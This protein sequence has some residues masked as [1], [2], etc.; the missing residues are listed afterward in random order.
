MIYTLFF[1][2]FARILLILVS[3]KRMDLIFITDRRL[4]FSFAP[5]VT[6]KIIYLILGKERK[7]WASNNKRKSY[8]RRMVSSYQLFNRPV[9]NSFE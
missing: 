5:V 7:N 4:N 3:F 8:S 9:G 2:L 1:F 6:I